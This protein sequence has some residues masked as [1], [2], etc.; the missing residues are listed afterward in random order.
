M[1]AMLSR[2]SR[3]RMSRAHMSAAEPATLPEQS[4]QPA[5]VLRNRMCERS[6]HQRSSASRSAI[7]EL[8]AYGNNACPSA[9]S[10]SAEH[11][12]CRSDARPRS[13]HERGSRIGS[14]AGAE[15]AAFEAMLDH[16]YEGHKSMAELAARP[17][18]RSLP[19]AAVGCSTVCARSSQS[20]QLNRSVIHRL[21][22]H[23]SN[24]TECVP[25]LARARQLG[26]SRARS[27]RE[28]CS[29]IIKPSSLERGKA[30]RSAGAVLAAYGSHAQPC[31]SEAHMSVAELE[32]R[33]GHSPPS[34]GASNECS[35]VSERSSH[36][37]GKVS[38]S[39]G[40]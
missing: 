17:D 40:T 24:V 23:R 37:R 11:K 34:T 1:V 10:A 33:T 2:V 4:S 28:L 5:Q 20:R 30:R 36:G 7:A 9:A 14:S 29:T 15:L 13:S 32:G 12:A 31:V 6:S 21:R 18:Q 25:N 3:V 35:T 38:S 39:A 27:L 26:R 19:S 8:A 16:L 22:W